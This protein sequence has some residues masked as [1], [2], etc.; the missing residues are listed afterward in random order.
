MTIEAVI[1]TDILVYAHDAADKTKHERARRVLDRLHGGGGFLTTQVLG[2][3]YSVVTRTLNPRMTS[4][5]AAE[6]LENLALSFPVLDV[7]SSIVLTAARD[8]ASHKLSYWDAQVWAT[9]LLNGVAV[10]LSEDCQ[11]GRSLAGVLFQ[12]PFAADFDWDLL[13]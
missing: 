1:D 2:E 13:G 3:F 10:V 8:A 12:N 6:Q 11:H 5:E 4:V 7:S 9:A